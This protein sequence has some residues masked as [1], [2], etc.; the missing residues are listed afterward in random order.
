MKFLQK[1]L[2]I[3]SVI[4]ENVIGIAGGTSFAPSSQRGISRINSISNL[5]A[6]ADDE[7]DWLPL[8]LRKYIQAANNFSRKNDID[9]PLGDVMQEEY[10]RT[11]TKLKRLGGIFGFKEHPITHS[12]STGIISI[13]ISC[14]NLRRVVKNFLDKLD[15]VVSADPKKSNLNQP[16]TLGHLKWI[17]Q[18]FAP[19]FDRIENPEPTD[20]MASSGLESDQIKLIL[21]GPIAK[22]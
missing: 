18:Y 5:A 21:N 13:D 6:F 10:D 15:Y 20:D 12:P 11:V 14:P 1:T 4:A 17:L 16:L 9:P 7:A 8:D 19:L 22:V 3:I 2:V